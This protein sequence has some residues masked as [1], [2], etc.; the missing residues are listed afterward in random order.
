MTTT[1]ADHA[2]AIAWPDT[3]PVPAW[4]QVRAAFP[5]QPGDTVLIGTEV[6]TVLR[7]EALSALRLH[8]LTLAA[9]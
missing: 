7:S 6:R 5:L 8:M 1:T 9:R 3:E 4:L 2:L